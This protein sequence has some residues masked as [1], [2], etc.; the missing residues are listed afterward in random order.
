MSSPSLCAASCPTPLRAP[1]PLLSFR[2]AAAIV[3]ASATRAAPAVSDDLVL[4]IAEQLEDSVTSSSSLLDPLRSA[5]ALS[6]L[7]TPWPTRRSSEAFRFTDVSYLR[8]LPISLPSRS[9]DLAPPSSPFPSHVLFSDG[10]LVSASG[11][12]VSALADLPPGRARDRAAAALAASAE[13]AHKDL[14]YDFN[15][16]GTR[17]IAVVH[18]PEGVKMADDPVHIMFTYTNSGGG[19][20]LM[21]NPRVL[22]V[23]E[24]EAEVAIVEE[25]FGAGEEGGC[26]WANPVA[27]IVIDEGARV[28][29]SYAQRQSFAAAHTKWTVVQQDTSSKYEFVEVSTGARLNRHNLHIQQLGPE[30]ETK[31]STLHLT[32]QN[33]QIHDLHSRLILDH[34][35]GFSRQLHKCIA[36]ATGN[37]IFDG[38][39]KVNRYAQQTDAGQETKCLIISPKALVNVKPNLQIIADDVKCTHGAAVSGELDPNEL[40][41]FQARGIDAQTATDALLFFFGAH[42]IKRIPFKPINEKTLA[43][44]KELLTSSRHTV[45][46]A[47]LS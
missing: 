24:K 41:Y 7:S 5:S 13:F 18:V 38:N 32:S 44:F 2:G 15:A 36:C 37:S 28:V 45:D 26:Y 29:H 30:T 20:M 23:A 22:V 3:S 4:R 14:F 43:Q 19:S 27:E 10:L 39:I 25:H 46:G 42:V 12:H 6:L 35:R 31:L 21:S 17:D 1:P 16:I 40:F 34:P 11:A 8:S 9:P 33:K 47:L